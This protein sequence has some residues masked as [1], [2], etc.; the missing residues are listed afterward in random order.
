MQRPF[1]HQL[2][3]KNIY[4]L[5]KRYEKKL[6]DGRLDES[7]FLRNNTLSNQPAR[8]TPFGRK[9]PLAPKTANALSHKILNFENWEES[10]E[11]KPFSDNKKEE[12][13]GLQFL[14]KLKLQPTPK[15]T[16]IRAT[17]VSEAM[18]TYNW[19]FEKSGR[20]PLSTD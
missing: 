18:Q 10:Q 16:L 2:I 20:Y 6:S 9:A 13:T 14:N 3:S 5:Q 1:Q 12:K 19:L 4:L 17:P 15:G 8:I 11:N 7:T